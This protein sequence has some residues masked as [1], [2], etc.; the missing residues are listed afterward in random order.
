MSGI[1]HMPRGVVSELAGTA[2]V[3][4]VTVHPTA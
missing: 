3:R 1:I 4:I 2:V